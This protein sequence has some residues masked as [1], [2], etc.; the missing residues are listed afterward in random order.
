M[1]KKSSIYNNYYNILD[2]RLITPTK[3][4]LKFIDMGSY[5]Q[6]YY[7]QDFKKIPKQTDT[8]FKKNLKIIKNL[9]ND[10]KNSITLPQLTEVIELKNINRSKLSCQRLA[11]A[12]IQYWK[13]FITLTYSDNFQD[14]SI[15]RK[16]FS[17]FIDS[18]RR[19]YKEF[20]YIAITEYQKRGSIHYHL[21][22]N[23]DKDSSLLYIQD[24]KYYHVKYWNKGFT[25]VEFINQD[26]QKI[27]GY[28]SKYMTKDIDN[29]LFNR[30]RYLYSQNLI[31]PI[32]NYLDINNE[33]QK[34]WLYNKL[35]HY[36]NV[37]YAKNITLFKEIAYFQEL[38]SF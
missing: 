34:K 25:S 4:N 1:T 13:S 36:Y 24:N 35:K 11:K 12:N 23:L 9:K 22:T 14:I 21:L 5:I 8:E 10:F 20:R 27:I 16:H 6:L 17:Y 26:Y 19:K 15:S 3:Y 18:I 33:K 38:T 32:I 31:K 2:S 28:I 7:Y 30:R 29:R 37:S